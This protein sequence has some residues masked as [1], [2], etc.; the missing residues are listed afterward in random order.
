MSLENITKHPD[1]WFEDGNIVLVAENTGF[2]VYRGLLVTHSGIFRDMFLL[3]QPAANPDNTFEG[4]SIVNLA[5][6]SAEEVA[7]LLNIVC[8]GV[9]RCVVVVSSRRI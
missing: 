6:D 4:C 7:A 1:L 3:P 9:D 8:N 5:D 2:R